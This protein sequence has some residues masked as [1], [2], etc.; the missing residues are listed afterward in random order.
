[1]NDSKL[2]WGDL[3]THLEDFDAGESI[4]RDARDNIDFTVVLLYPFLYESASGL[5]VESVGHRPEFALPWK[6]INELAATFNE[7]GHFT[8]FPGYEWHGDR[9]RYGDHNVIY[10][11]EDQPLD[12]AWSL[13][14]LY[15]HLKTRKAMAIPHHTGYRVGARGKAWDT[16]DPTLSP[17]MEIFSQHGS[18]EGIE[19]PHF[20]AH[21]ASMGPGASGG[22]FQDAL[23]RGLH[24]GV[25]GS[26]DGPG[27]P[28]R[29]GIGRA[30]VW[31]TDNTRSAIWEAIRARRTY[32]VTGDRINL[33]FAIHDAPMGS[34]IETH[35][36]VEADVKVIGSGA[37][38][39]IEMLRG[40]QVIDTYI[41]RIT[42]PRDPPTRFKVFVEAGWG[43]AAH[44]GFRLPGA[45]WAWNGELRVR[46]GRI[47]GV[48]KCF[49]LPGQRIV[50]CD[51]SYCAWIWKT[52]V[53]DTRQPFGMRQGLVFELEGSALTELEWR[54]EQTRVTTLMGALMGEAVVLP[55]LGEVTN[56]AQEQFGVSEGE[57]KNPDAYYQNA[58]KIVIHPA[59]P[60]EQ[61]NTA[62]T[63]RHLE[64]SPGMNPFYVRVTQRNGQMAWS[65]P[66]WVD[67]HHSP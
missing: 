30:A 44:N 19:S 15:A 55:L 16:F 54:I 8:T 24:I 42:T 38:E 18:S 23:Q 10:F 58:R 28:G 5:R 61:Y 63:F 6:R 37:I 56:L 4:L 17:V 36:E 57:I 14:E 39:R 46:A 47:V 60:Q 33:D 13:T 67:S 25:I 34:V 59:I 53:R 2:L 51:D 21:N 35:S 62:Y 43:P 3:H 9:T 20:M 49:S 12:P 65:S 41:P 66:I 26:N 64:L 32:A 48:E 52:A 11:N 29:W 22:T 50:A 31:A 40:A 45:T 27:L 7:P 1:M